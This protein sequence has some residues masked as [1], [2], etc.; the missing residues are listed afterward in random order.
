LLWVDW[1]H[2][3]I[4]ARLHIQTEMQK[5]LGEQKG[6][7]WTPGKALYQLK[8]DPFLTVHALA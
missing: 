2:P 1:H 4:E 8:R 6:V 5:N 7:S 3:K